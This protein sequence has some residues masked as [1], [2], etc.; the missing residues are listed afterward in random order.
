MQCTS[1]FGVDEMEHLR[2]RY[3]RAEAR[4]EEAKDRYDRIRAVGR[5]YQ[6]SWKNP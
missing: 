1:R 5:M 6:M 3:E 2:E 4:I